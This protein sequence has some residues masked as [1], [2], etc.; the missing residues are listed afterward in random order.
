MTYNVTVDNANI[1]YFYLT[2]N[3]TDV[4]YQFFVDVC[5]SSSGPAQTIKIQPKADLG[6]ANVLDDSDFVTI[7]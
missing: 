6:G 5:D 3:Y 2:P 1:Q 7:R 4:I